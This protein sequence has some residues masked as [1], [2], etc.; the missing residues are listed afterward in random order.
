M[1]MRLLD[2]LLSNFKNYNRTKLKQFLKYGSITVNGQVETAFNYELKPNDSVTIL[3]RQSAL[4]L[5]LKSN[6]SFPILYEDNFLIVVEK[7]AGLLTMGTDKDRLNTLYFELT[8]YIKSQS[9]KGIGRIFIVHRLDR[10]ASGLVVFAKTESVKRTLQENWN[11]VLKKYYAVVEGKPMKK[12]DKIESYLVE[13]KF[14]RVY[15]TNERAR[16]AKHAETHYLVLESNRDY[17]LL[18]V[19]L[20]TGRKN[21]IRVHLSDIGCPIAGDEK[22][23]AQSDPIGRLALHAY[24]LSFKH[25]ET[26]ELKTFKTEMPWPF[27]SLFKKP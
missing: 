2:Y 14:K 7:P 17:S 13:D 4:R 25:P 6:L 15:S 22:Y 20:V 11:D 18:D 5:A 8:E 26:G 10:D 21:Q 9:P 24:F 16:D 23:G 1:K 27:A 12:A 3:D 19:N